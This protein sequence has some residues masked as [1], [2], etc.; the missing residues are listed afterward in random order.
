MNVQSSSLEQSCEQLPASLQIIGPSDS[1]AM[2]S[3]SAAHV[4]VQKP[5]PVGPSS[6]LASPLV[7]TAVG[8]GSGA[9]VSPP[10]SSA[11][12]VE[13][14]GSGEGVEPVVK[15]A[16]AASSSGPVL[17]SSPGSDHTSVSVPSSGYSPMQ[18]GRLS[19]TTERRRQV[20]RIA[21]FC[22]APTRPV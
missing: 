12:I 1:V 7:P 10:L 20:A 8:S 5:G 19:S 22:S 21:T 18:A 11:A 13:P 6:S 17:K 15:P 16:S 4:C 14:F 2:Q 9:S 3:E